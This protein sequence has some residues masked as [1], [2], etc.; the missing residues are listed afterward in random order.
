MLMSWVP[1]CVR[2]QYE[3]WS[4]YFRPCLRNAL[5]PYKT[6]QGRVVCEDGAP[7]ASPQFLRTHTNRALLRAVRRRMMFRYERH[8]NDAD[9]LQPERDS[10]DDDA[11]SEPA[12]APETSGDEDPAAA[13][14]H[15]REELEM[16]RDERP[17]ADG[18]EQLGAG[19]VDEWQRVTLAQRLSAAQ[20][21]DAAA[22]LRIGTSAI[23]A[24]GVSVNPQYDWQTVS[25]THL[26]LPTIC[27]V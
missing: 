1:A 25:Y 20:S 21:A 19:D 2:E 15:V 3:R 14:R 6:H 10:E 22:D 18:V 23:F 13:A 8:K 4:P 9:L 24:D 11:R 27:S 16:V 17:T 12:A 5:R 7:V 26:T